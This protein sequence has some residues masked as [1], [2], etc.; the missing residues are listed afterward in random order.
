MIALWLFACSGDTAPEP[1]AT[2]P[3]VEAPAPAAPTSSMTDAAPVEGHWLVHISEENLAG[4]E[5]M[6]A[7]AEANPEDARAAM[8]VDM[9]SKL[10]ERELK[11]TPTTIS[12]VIK[13]ETT[14]F[15]GTL[16]PTDAGWQFEAPDAA[17]VF[18]MKILDD[19]MLEMGEEGKEPQ[20]WKRP[21]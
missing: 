14:I 1:A 19:G 20:R 9:L 5:N 4:L 12:F 8:M 15:N 17:K 3:A 7:H 2:T 16:S 6:K 11:L 13:G 18:Q 21:A 10:A